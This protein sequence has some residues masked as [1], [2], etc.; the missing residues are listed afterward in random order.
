MA[1]G[2]GV[3]PLFTESES[4]VLPLNDPPIPKPHSLPTAGRRR[5]QSAWRFVDD[6]IINYFKP[7]TPSPLRAIGSSEPEA[8]P[9]PSRGEGKSKRDQSRRIF[10]LRVIKRSFIGISSWDL[11]SIFL[12]TALPFFNSSSPRMRTYRALNL[13]ALRI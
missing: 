7:S 10:A 13:S 9:S 2:K 1:G 11:S 5:G 12:S 6:N 3:E 8:P 4:V